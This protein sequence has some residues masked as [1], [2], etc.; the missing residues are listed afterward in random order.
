[1]HRMLADLQNSVAS[2]VSGEREKTLIVKSP[3]TS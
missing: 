3:V 2:H 1:M